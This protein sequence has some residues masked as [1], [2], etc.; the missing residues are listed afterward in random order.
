MSKEN[1]E[2][3]QKTDKRYCK[4]CNDELELNDDLLCAACSYEQA[5]G[6]D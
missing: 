2:Q 6:K 3:E 1:K 5:F 4:W